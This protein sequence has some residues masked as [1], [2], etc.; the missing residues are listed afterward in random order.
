MVI[1]M[2]RPIN[3]KD[4]LTRAALTSAPTNTSTDK[5]AKP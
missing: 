1:A 4:L 5:N 3:L 2:S